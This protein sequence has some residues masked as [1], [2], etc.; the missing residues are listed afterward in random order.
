MDQVTALICRQSHTTIY[1]ANSFTL[2][3]PTR[4]EFAPANS[5]YYATAYLP[6]RRLFDH[7]MKRKIEI[8]KIYF[9]FFQGLEIISKSGHK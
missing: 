6:G 7:Y 2:R 5:L 4:G 3:F 1:F 8:R 9:E